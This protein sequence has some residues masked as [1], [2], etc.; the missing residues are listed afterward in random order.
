MLGLAK[1]AFYSAISESSYAPPGG[2][3]RTPL[4]LYAE[5]GAAASSS[6]FNTGT[7]SILLDGTNDYVRL[8]A[9]DN[10]AFAL[11][12]FTMEMWGYQTSTSGYRALITNWEH[13]FFFAVV[14]GNQL[15]MY[16]NATLVVNATGLTIPSNSWNHFA[17]TRNG[18][19]VK[20]F[21]NGT[22]VGSTGSFGTQINPTD[23][24]GIGVNVNN[25]PGGNLGSFWA[26][27]LDEVR[28]SD[29]ARYNS[30][31]TTTIAPFVND[32][33]TVLLVHGDTDISDDGSSGGEVTPPVEPVTLDAIT[34]PANSYLYNTV[35]A[36]TM[37]TTNSGTFSAWFK[38]DNATGGNFLMAP[39]NRNDNASYAGVIIY[40]TGAGKV[41]AY[42]YKGVNNGW[43]MQ[44]YGNTVLQNN[45]W[46]HIAVTW[47]RT[48]PFATSARIYINGI[49][50]SLSNVR[51]NNDTDGYNLLTEMNIHG[52][53]D[54]A[55]VNTTNMSIGQVYFNDSWTDLDTNLNW[56]Y[57]TGMSGPVEMGT[58]GTQSGAPKPV[59]YH[60]GNTSTF[61]TNNGRNTGTY[62]TYTFTPT[63]GTPTDTTTDS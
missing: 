28:V 43:V 52:R 34:L 56:F 3:T 1:N 46:Y 25:Y 48:Q 8:D 19:D 63:G 44:F 10:S 50:E 60:Y 12:D 5:N 6:Q 45:T 16:I 24:T 7:G 35:T 61:Y 4:M 27:Y 21:L 51:Y 30:N 18:S 59:S 53:F 17:V 57:D 22:Q 39:T 62:L 13:G 42:G 11:D 37:T 20:I 26:G 49:Q 55:Y 36:N 9:S 29:T 47:D 23:F 31:F 32:A 40:I 54:P 14:N 58:D 15:V 38:S 2:E 33:N 41:Q